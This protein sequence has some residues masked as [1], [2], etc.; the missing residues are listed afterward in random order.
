MPARRLEWAVA[1]GFAGWAL[2]RATAADRLLSTEAQVVALLSF[3]PQAS[4]AA[5]AAA[6]LMRDRRASALSAAAA[7]VL[8]AVVVPRGVSR[9]QPPAAGPVLRVIT[10]NLLV[11]RADPEPV[12]AMVWAARADVLFVQELSAEK[13]RDLRRAGLDDL[14]PHAVSDAGEP[15]PRGNAI[16]SRYPLT[17]CPPVPSAPWAQPVAT[18]ALPEGVARLA[19]VH[20]PAPKPLRSMSGATAWRRELRK[21]RAMPAPEGQCTILAGDFNSTL[22]HAEFRELLCRG[23]ADAASQ[24]GNGLVPTW[25]SRAGRRL[26]LLTID[27]VLVSRRCAVLG[28]AVHSLPGTD[29]R[30]VIAVIRL[31]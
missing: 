25:A 26:G 16:Y 23:Y 13:A 31:P 22:D 12:V 18:L 9:R 17:P 10:A 3:T 24:A 20:L 7:S 27:H 30:A 5:W 15:E 4:A 8:T 28:T 2:A 29:H 6:L 14:L 21:L 19:C 1:G 11:G